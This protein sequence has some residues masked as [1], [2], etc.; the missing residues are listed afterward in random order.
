M[1]K[2]RIEKF[3][4][5]AWYGDFRKLGFIK[6][7]QI[8]VFYMVFLIPCCLFYLISVYRKAFYKYGLL[9]SYHPGIP[10]IIVGNITVG[11]TG[12]TPIVI[13][14]V[15][16]LKKQGLKPAVITRGYLSSSKTSTPA[17]L[18]NNSDPA[19]YGDEAV[20]IYNNTNIPV[21]VG[22]NR[23]ESTKLILNH[24]DCNIIISD[25]GLQHYKL[26]RDLEICVVD[27]TRI[28]GNKMLLPL[29]PLREPASRLKSCDFILNKRVLADCFIDLTTM[30]PIAVSQFIST[31]SK[32]SIIAVSGIGNNNSFFDTLSILGVTN[33]SAKS[34][35]DHFDYKDFCFI[36]LY[37]ANIDDTST[38]FITTEKDAVKLTEKHKDIKIFYLKI[39]ADLDAVFIGDFENAIMTLLEKYNL[40]N[41]DLQSKPQ[42]TNKINSKESSIC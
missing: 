18:N 36:D 3:L 40:N 9:K 22:A 14:L 13:E 10:V 17:L 35:P 5:D 21:V 20:L 41:S 32:S 34:L 15:K 24:T 39:K 28:L 2:Q 26:K 16:I 25:D 8:A 37:G 23:V 38:V 29:G 4:L 30:Q 27:K 11:G 6:K 12:K 1:F 33:F 31:Y 7:L 19:K 42:S